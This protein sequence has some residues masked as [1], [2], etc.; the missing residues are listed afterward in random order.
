MLGKNQDDSWPLMSFII[1]SASQDYV[2]R[3]FLRLK[4]QIK[5]HP[6]YKFDF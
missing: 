2:I 4:T 1:I 3:T 6:I 5:F